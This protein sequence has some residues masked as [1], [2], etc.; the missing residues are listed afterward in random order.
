M[1]GEAKSGFPLYGEEPR[2]DPMSFIKKY[3]EQETIN[4]RNLL[5]AGAY[6]LGGAAGD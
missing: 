5:L 3:V 6:G 2:E 1:P 4:R